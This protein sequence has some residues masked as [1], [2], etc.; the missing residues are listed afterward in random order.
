MLIVTPWSAFW[1]QNFFAEALPA[2]EPVIRNNFVRG[3][4][5]GV[6]VVTTIAGLVELMGLLAGRRRQGEPVEPGSAAGR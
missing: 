1:D 2:L 6:G 3:A 4:V 5:S